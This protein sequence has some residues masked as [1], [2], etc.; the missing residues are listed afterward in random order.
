MPPKVPLHPWEWPERPW[1]R[2]HVDYA[3][4]YLGKWFLLAVD[5]HSKWIEVAIVPSAT[6]TTTIE[7]SRAIF[8]THGLPETIVSDNETVFTSAEFQ[9]FTKRNNIK[10]IR[11]APSFSYSFSV[12]FIESLKVFEESSGKGGTNFQ[13]LYE[14][15]HL[16]KFG[17]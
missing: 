7:K 1:W 4:P 14:K 3:G 17:N 10:H 13:R 5:A 16:R 8:A 6:S 2:S 11:T 9:E 12:F 15:D